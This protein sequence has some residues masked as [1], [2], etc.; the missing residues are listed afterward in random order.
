MLQ[1]D[2]PL[3]GAVEQLQD[4]QRKNLE[5]LKHTTKKINKIVDKDEDKYYEKFLGVY[6]SNFDQAWKLMS[7]LLVTFIPNLF[8]TVMKY[9]GNV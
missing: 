4:I 6:E 8:N 3:S 5:E 1:N 7:L 9:A 2:D